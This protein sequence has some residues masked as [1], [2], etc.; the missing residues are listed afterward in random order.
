MRLHVTPIPD[1]WE[2]CK[3]SMSGGFNHPAWATDRS[4]DFLFPS[5]QAS[6]KKLR[7]ESALMI[8]RCIRTEMSFFVGC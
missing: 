8:F 7:A 3:G 2:E 4:L 6:E 5:P 1:T